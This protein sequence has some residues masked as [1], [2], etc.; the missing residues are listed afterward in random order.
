MK[1]WKRLL[2][3]GIVM[4]FLLGCVSGQV[5]SPRTEA[6][7]TEAESKP[8]V[9]RTI[10]EELT[11]VTETIFPINPQATNTETG[12]QPAATETSLADQP[13]PAKMDDSAQAGLVA[14]VISV[15]VKGEPGV[16]QFSV[17]VRSPDTGCEQYADWWEVLSEDGQLLY[18][19]ILLHSHVGEQPFVRSGGPVSIEAETTVWVRAHMNV[20]GYGGQAFKGSVRDGFVMAELEPGFASDLAQLQPLPAG[21]N[22]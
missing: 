14:D 16:Y 4:S 2:V 8:Q 7:E 15:Q 1:Y 22:F 5:N 20:A 6:L 17:E 3:A 11:E 21:C 13:E 9:T 18:R 12:D 10:S 19:R